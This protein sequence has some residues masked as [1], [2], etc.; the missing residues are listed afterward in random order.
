MGL[1]DFDAGGMK[2]LGLPT[3]ILRLRHV[4][5]PVLVRF[6]T[7]FL[8]L[9]LEIILLGSDAEAIGNLEPGEATATGGEGPPMY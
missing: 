3:L 4:M 9:P 1:K 6:L 8:C 5:Q 2:E 7:S